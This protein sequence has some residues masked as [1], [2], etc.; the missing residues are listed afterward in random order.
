MANSIPCKRDHPRAGIYHFVGLP[1]GAFVIRGPPGGG[2]FVFFQ[3]WGISHFYYL[4]QI[5]AFF[6]ALHILVKGEI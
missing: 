2:V 5:S 1:G 3:P 4:S 6:K